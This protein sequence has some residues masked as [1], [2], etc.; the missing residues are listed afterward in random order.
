MAVTR[1]DIFRV[2]KDIRDEVGRSRSVLVR[3]GSPSVS[4]ALIEARL[5]TII[6]HVDGVEALLA[7][8]DADTSILAAI[9]FATSAKQ[10]TLAAIDYAT[11]NRQDV[12]IATDFSTAANQAALNAKDFATT[13]KQDTLIAKDF[14]T[15]AKQ[16]VQETSLNAIQTLLTTL[17]ALIVVVDSVL[18]NIKTSNDGIKTNTEPEGG[19]SL[20]SLMTSVKDAIITGVNFDL[21]TDIENNTDGIESRLTN[22][23]P[24]Y[25][26]TV[27][28]VMIAA[29]VADTDAAIVNTGQ[30]VRYTAHATLESVSMNLTITPASGK[31][32]EI[33]HG[34]HKYSGTTAI[35]FNVTIETDAIDLI[36]ST[37]LLST[38]MSNNS[39]DTI[40]NQFFTKNTAG[41]EERFV[42]ANDQIIRIKASTILD[43]NAVYTIYLWC[44][45]VDDGI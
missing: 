20:V 8:I 34:Y 9:D 30:T 14:A 36:K 3:G 42:D 11:A 38:T 16:N 35:T 22:L 4:V 1:E 29:I 27:S 6:G 44:R 28:L 10:D 15:A 37:R 31:V 45:Q 12:L 5:T 26:N 43:A 18:D 33:F 23:I 25:G 7:T 13:A 19:F 21:L 2:L 17:N 32:I 39:S 40:D 24:N 41:R